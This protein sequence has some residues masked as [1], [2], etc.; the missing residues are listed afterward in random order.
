VVRFERP[1]VLR[2]NLRGI[3]EKRLHDPHVAF[4]ARA[5]PGH[6]KGDELVCLTEITSG[7]LT[8][9]GWRMVRAGA[10]HGVEEGAVD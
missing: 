3:P 10:S 5:N 6:G 7:N 2:P 4:F 8:R 1:Q 9:A